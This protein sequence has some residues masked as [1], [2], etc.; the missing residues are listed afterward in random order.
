VTIG[1]ESD[2]LTQQNVYCKLT[3]EDLSVKY[4]TLTYASV[5]DKKQVKC[6]LE[7]NLNSINTVQFIDVALYMNPTPMDSFILS[8]N[9]ETYLIVPNL[10]HWRTKRFLNQTE[11]NST[12]VDYQIPNRNFNY[13]IQVKGDYQNPSSFADVNCTYINGDYPKCNLPIV[14]F[15]QLN[16]V[17]LKLNFSLLI[18]HPYTKLFETVSIDY[19]IYFTT[20]DFEMVKPFVVSHI[21]RKY[22]NSTVVSVMKYQLNTK[23]FTF[24]LNGFFTS[25]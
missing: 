8:S 16:M 6:L 2:L 20:I 5:S 18:S 15:E 25:F 21:E 1:L 14:Y 4:S 19:L 13:K 9:N 12:V 17:P 23:D 11:L 24:S 3:F 22:S 10:L 7:R